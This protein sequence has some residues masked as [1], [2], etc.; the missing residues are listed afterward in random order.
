VRNL[1][2]YQIPA[3]S[4]VTFSLFL[5]ETRLGS[6]IKMMIGSATQAM[7]T[8]NFRP[9]DQQ[10]NDQPIG[11]VLVADEDYTIRR[12]L[13]NT[14]FEAGFDVAEA[15]GADEA[16]ALA[17]AIRCDVAL[18]AARIDG[19]QPVDICGELRAYCPGLRVLMLTAGDNESDQLEALDAGADDCIAKPLRMSE[20]LAR[21]R[22]AMRRTRSQVP[23]HAI[24]RIG[25][26]EA[27][28][29]RRIVYKAGNMIH[30]TPK[31]FDLLVY[32]MRHA[33]IPIPHRQI[34]TAVWGREHADRVDYLRTFMRQLRRKLED[35]VDTPRYL[36]TNNY[37]GY[38][39][40]DKSELEAG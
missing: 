5:S 33:G 30:V 10:E 9:L 38:R 15:S 39:F 6:K 3:E 37:I 18:M 40:A 7:S 24:L 31:E 34:L 20:V 11:R 21:V 19:R 2:G 27:N 32:L 28:L 1:S 29:S 23:G 14:L 25:E 22:A 12:A 35:H 13:H 16:I 4:F 26:I 36:L 8:V 17:Q